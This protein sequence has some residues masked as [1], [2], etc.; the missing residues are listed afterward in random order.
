MRTPALVEVVV[1]VEESAPAFSIP[2]NPKE[3]RDPF[4]AHVHPSRREHNVEGCDSERCLQGEHPGCSHI[5]YVDFSLLENSSVNISLIY[6]VETH[7][8]SIIRL[9]MCNGVSLRDEKK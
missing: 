8:L 1:G 9:S 6:V 2:W 5:L 7:R 3:R 4:P